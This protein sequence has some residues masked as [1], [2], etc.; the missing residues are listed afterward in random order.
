[1]EYTTVEAAKAYGEFVGDDEDSLI[2][3]LILSA[4]QIIDQYTKRT[5]AVDDEAIRTFRRSRRYDDPIDGLILLLDTDLAEAAS[6]IADVDDATWTPTVFYREENTPP[7][8]GIEL[9]ED[10][11]PQQTEVTGYW[12]YSRTPPVDIEYACLRLVKWLY[13]MRDTTEG[14]IPIVTAEGRVLLPEGIPTDVMAIILPYCRL[15][16][17]R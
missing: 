5:F 14:Q 6:K 9:T 10:T 8:W 17:G 4:S 7:Y 12:G 11:W 1:M 2:N 15:Q 16:V 3:A 13:D